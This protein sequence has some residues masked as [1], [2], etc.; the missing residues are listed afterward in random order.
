MFWRKLSDGLVKSALTFDAFV[1]AIRL[2]PDG[3]LWRHNQAGDLPGDSDHVDAGKLDRLARA[4]A[5]TRG[6]T[7]TH[8]P[9]TKTNVR[10]VKNATA[11][12]FTI[13]ASADRTADVDAIMD[14]G[15]PTV[16]VLPSSFAGKVTR[17]AKGRRIIGC[18]ATY[19]DDVTCSGCGN[20][21]PLCQRADRDYAIGFPAHGASKRKADA[22]VNAK[23]AR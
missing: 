7:Y 9:L 20:G 17:T 19:R 1:D 11:K 6:W 14:I 12:G 3:Q 16:T 10:A 4:A 5:H 2:L 18:P 13:N 22:V 23:S 8:K 21:R 15:L